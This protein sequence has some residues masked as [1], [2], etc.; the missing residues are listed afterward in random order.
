MRYSRHIEN[1]NLRMPRTSIFQDNPI[2]LNER[3]TPCEN[4]LERIHETI[5]GMLAHH[6]H[7]KVFR[8]DMRLPPEYQANYDSRKRP[9]ISRFFS[10]LSSK[11]NSAI[12]RRQRCGSRVH[13]TQLGYI[14]AREFS[15]NGRPHFH[16]VIIINKQTFWNLGAYDPLSDCLYG[17]ICQAWASAL[18]YQPFEVAPMVHIP[19]NAGYDLRRDEPYEGLFYRLSYLAKVETKVY[20]SG[21]NFGTS[22][23]K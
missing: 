13:P 15:T 21:K 17:L 3:C 20:G 6:S 9:L 19:E 22:S 2:I 1:R 5:Q 10:S 7:L 18:G 8:F 11:I 16:C 23:I 12:Q 4:Y 14:W